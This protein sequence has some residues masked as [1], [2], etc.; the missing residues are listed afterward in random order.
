MKLTHSSNVREESGLGVA[1]TISD[2]YSHKAGRVATHFVNTNVPY[3]V[4]T[5][6]SF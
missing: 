4:P 3:D 5:S 6:N 2:P 1:D